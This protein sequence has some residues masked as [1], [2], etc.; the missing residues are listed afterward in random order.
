MAA[1][2]GPWL[3]PAFFLYYVQHTVTQRKWLWLVM[4]MLPASLAANLQVMPFPWF[5]LLAVLLLEVG[6]TALLYRVHRW[7]VGGQ[8]AFSWTL[9]FPALWTVREFIE[10]RGDMGTFASIANTQYAFPWLVQL[11][12]WTG[13]WG[14]TFLLYWF[15]SVLGWAVQARLAGRSCRLGFSV[16]AAVLGTV[17]GLGAYRYHTNQ[18]AQAP[19]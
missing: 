13:L 1:T 17:L 2:L 7:L 3:A 4:A 11:V 10:T 19:A 15:G 6:K 16:Y 18:A 14:I 12:S 8:T 5:I 9:V